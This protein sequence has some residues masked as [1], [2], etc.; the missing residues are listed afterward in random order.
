MFTEFGNPE[1]QVTIESIEFQD[2]N[3]AIE[4]GTARVIIPGRLPMDSEYTT[5]QVKRNGEWKIQSISESEIRPND[6]QDGQLKE[7]AWLI[8]NWV[9]NSDEVKVETKY[10]WILHKHFIQ[11]KFTVYYANHKQLNGRQLI[12]WDPVNKEIRSW[13]FDSDGGRGEGVW[14]KE[15]NVWNVHVTSILPDGSKGSS[16]HTY[17]LINK[18]SFKYG[19]KGRAVDGY[20]LPNINEVTITRTTP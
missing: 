8:G 19:I 7:L 17:I 14:S 15:G 2:D 11:S 3:R 10:Q 13:I 16:I 5:I 1:L 6:I 9:D 18:E 20:I 12:G 4:R